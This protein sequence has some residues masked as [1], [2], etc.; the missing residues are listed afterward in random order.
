[1]LGDILSRI[2]EALRNLVGGRKA[3]FALIAIV[4][5]VLLNY[6]PG[7]AAKIETISK[8]IAIVTGVLIFGITV[9]DSLSSWAESR[10]SAL[11]ELLR[12]LLEA[13]KGTEETPAPAPTPT[14]VKEVVGPRPDFVYLSQ[15][16]LVNLA[17]QVQSLV[18]QDLAKQDP[19]Q[20]PPKFPAD[21]SKG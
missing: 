13:L 19:T 4:T 11:E 15:D 12:I 3:L 1:M 7:E 6:A 14:G 2:G 5:L 10:S 21:E 18:K 8:L 20:F 16:E 17:R 9:E